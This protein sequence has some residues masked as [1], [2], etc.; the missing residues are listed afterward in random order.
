[1][2]DELAR[3]TKTCAAANIIRNEQMEKHAMTTNVKMEIVVAAIRWSSNILEDAESNF[4]GKLDAAGYPEL[5]DAISSLDAAVEKIR[6]SQHEENKLL[7]MED[8]R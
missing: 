4:D 2:N 8:K 6:A 5:R 1:M 3:T 7:E